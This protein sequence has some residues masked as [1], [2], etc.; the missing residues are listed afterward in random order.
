MLPL[1]Y[2]KNFVPYSPNDRGL[3]E[4]V[5]DIEV[6]SGDRICLH[7]DSGSGK[8][9]FLKSL[10]LLYPPRSGQV[11]FQNQQVT[12][13]QILSFRSNVIYLQQVPHFGEST[14]AEEFKRV[15]SFKIYRHKQDLLHA[16]GLELAKEIGLDSDIFASKAYELSGGQKQKL[17][18]VLGLCLDPQIIILDEPT[19]SLDE[20]STLEVEQL[21]R[22]WTDQSVK[23][24]AYIWVS[25]QSSQ[26][27]RVANIFYQIQAGRLLSDT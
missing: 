26:R 13:K 8:S 19:A 21:L 11:Y 6:K 23:E 2:T 27:Q 18:L 22:N 1:L 17:H 12:S 15:F 25:H 24:R 14:I 10:T 16:K 4:G 5:W 9:L 7:G 3:F 20:R